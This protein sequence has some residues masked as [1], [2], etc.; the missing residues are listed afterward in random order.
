[1]IDLK[2]VLIFT[3]VFYNLLVLLVGIKE[4]RTYENQMSKL[5]FDDRIVERYSQATGL[6]HS[7]K[8][9]PTTKV[10]FLTFWVSL[11]FAFLIFG[12]G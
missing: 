2:N 5:S 9:L 3:T 4:Y 8:F 12:T 1:M 6:E 11:I 7:V 10:L